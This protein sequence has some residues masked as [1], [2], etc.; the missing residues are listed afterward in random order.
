MAPKRKHSGTVPPRKKRKQ[1]AAENMGK[2]VEE[3]KNGLS[4]RKA[5]EQYNIPRSTLQE[6]VT[7]KRLDGAILG[8]HPKLTA[9][10]EKS[11]ADHCKYRADHS[12]R[13]WPP[14]NG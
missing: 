9:D 12:K 6:H 5:A 14:V 4:L 1:W 10:Q 7:G 2:A 8:K 3:V 13:I 11:L